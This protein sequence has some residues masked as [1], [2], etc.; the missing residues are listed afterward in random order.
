MDE[1]K[2]IAG[3]HVIAMLAQG[4]MSTIYQCE[5][6]EDARVVAIKVLTPHAARA[7]NKVTT[8]LKK[9]WEGQR[10][11][12]LIHPNVVR[13]FDCGRWRDTYYIV[14]EYLGG[15][16]LSEHLE[17]SSPVIRG[18]RLRIL[19]QAAHGLSYVHQAGII[20]RDVCPRNVMLADDGTAKVIDFGVAMGKDDRLRNTGKRTG[21]ANYMAPEVV[22]D[23]VFNECTDIYAFGIT[24]YETLAGSKPFEGDN[25]DATMYRQMNVAPI[26]PSRVNP[27]I[28]IELE[29]I[30]VKSLSKNPD[31]RYQKMDEVFVALTALRGL[32]L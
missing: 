5:R 11:L 31:D 27:N 24:L 26:P 1:P 10:A 7:A 17:R 29:A 18:Q 32:E 22:H 19:T 3:N 9:K 28:P 30:I 23:N 14:M 4:P 6:A 15:G 2:V 25:R 13:T 8:K 16:N 12:T 20:H 21:R